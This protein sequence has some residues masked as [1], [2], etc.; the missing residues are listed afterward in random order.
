[1]TNSELHVIFGAGPVGRAVARELVKRGKSVKMINRSGKKPE[2]VPDGVTIAA[3]DVFDVEVAKQLAQGAS[4]VYQCTNP[5]YNHWPEQFPALQANTLEAAAS[6]GA[7]Y[8]VMENLYMY[9]DTN[10]QPITEDLPY[11]AQTKKGKVRAQMA[12]DVL[13]AHATGKVRA[14]MARASDFYGPGVLES[15]AGDRVFGF[16]MEGK[17]A[18]V[19]GNLDA[20]HSYTYID[21]IGKALVILGEQDAALGRAWHVPNVPATTTREFINLIFEA[22]GQPAKMSAMGKLMLRLGGLFIPAA[23]EIIEMMYEFEQD[24][25]VDG[26]KF[27]KTFGLQATPYREGIKATVAWYKASY[28]TTK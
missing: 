26:S 25:V 15:A 18:S 24:F 13:T 19:A 28:K 20:R 12:K 21:D 11:N 10:G 9:G 6:A 3:G 8:I 2:G 27:T 1:M 14:A 17:A 23:R 22:L 5:P 7:K 16:A 4:H